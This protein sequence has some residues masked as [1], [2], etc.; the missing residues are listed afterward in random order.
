[1][2]KISMSQ[3]CLADIIDTWI[4]EKWGCESDQRW[5]SGGSWLIESVEHGVWVICEENRVWVDGP[6]RGYNLY[7][8]DPNFFIDLEARI[9]ETI[10]L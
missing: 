7:P 10:D 9:R 5:G 4:K 6:N 2:K 3:P 8:T 1:M